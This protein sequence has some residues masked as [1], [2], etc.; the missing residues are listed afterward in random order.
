MTNALYQPTAADMAQLN[1]LIQQP[2]F[3]VLKKL[4]QSEVDRF[5]VE[6]MNTDP[7]EDNYDKKVQTRHNIA[8]AAAMFYQKLMNR[9]YSEQQQ[10]VS[11]ASGEKVQSDGTAELLGI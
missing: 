7:T 8:L 6:L 11:A 2:G 4:M 9:V 3:E 10:F 1:S 5:Q